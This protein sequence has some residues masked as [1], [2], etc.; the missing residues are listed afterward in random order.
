MFQLIW[1]VYINYKIWLSAWWP[2]VIRLFSLNSRQARHLYLL[3]KS[4]DYLVWGESWGKHGIYSC[5][6]WK[7][8]LNQQLDQCP[9][10]KARAFSLPWQNFSASIPPLLCYVWFCG[11]ADW[12]LGQWICG[13]L[14]HS[15]LVRG[16]EQADQTRLR[17][18]QW[19]MELDHEGWR[20]RDVLLK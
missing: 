5:Q 2:V 14:V 1:A 18:V 4:L 9:P 3:C 8:F 19:N 6:T 11:K 17:G 15:R 20:S 13:G 12:D 16:W 7:Y 10:Q